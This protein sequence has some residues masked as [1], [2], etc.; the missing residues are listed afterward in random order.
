M[1]FGIAMTTGESERGNPV[2]FAYFFVRPS[3]V[4][5]C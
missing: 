3:W 5:K 1:F 4:Y 2:C